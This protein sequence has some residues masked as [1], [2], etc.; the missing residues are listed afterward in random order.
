MKFKS[1]KDMHV[2]E[3][4][5]HTANIAFCKLYNETIIYTDKNIN[6]R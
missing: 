1:V 3:P 2:Y 5:Q 6:L 4:N